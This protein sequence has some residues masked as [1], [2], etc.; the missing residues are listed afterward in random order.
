ML[1][2]PAVS[3]AEEACAQ[4]VAA[5]YP[6]FATAAKLFRYGQPPT[7]PDENCAFSSTDLGS[8]KEWMERID[9]RI[10]VHELR[11]LLHSSACSG[12]GT[13]RALVE[14]YLSKIDKTGSDRDKLDY[15]L[16]H[17]T[18]SHAAAESSSDELDLEQ[19][20]KILEPLLGESSAE[21]PQWLEPLETLMDE[22]R[23]C[24]SLRE[25]DESEI[26][27]RGRTIKIE[28]RDMYFGRSSL[29]AFA[30]FN[31]LLGRTFRRLLHAELKTTEAILDDLEARAVKT[32]DCT[33]ISLGTAEPLS[34]LRDMCRNWQQPTYQDYTDL[35]FQRIVKLREALE[36]KLAATPPTPE[37][38]LRYLELRLQAVTAEMA[39][40]R[41]FVVQGY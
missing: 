36:T 37:S 32:I 11:K 15:L 29:V 16:A 31:F 27:Q 35:S 14:R 38:R 1:A 2:G 24:G 17:W 19:T 3:P 8:V 4:A 41:R 23:L 6:F 7:S 28:G 34:A 5:E 12:D 21:L 40:L 22:L 25:L 10:A 30:R 39:S 13:S 18:R 26:I 33:S 20:A 9:N